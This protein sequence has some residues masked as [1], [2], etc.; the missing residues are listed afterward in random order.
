MENI[1]F[2]WENGLF[3]VANS[4]FAWENGLFA[5]GNG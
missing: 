4:S 1:S 3:A 2:A 5:D